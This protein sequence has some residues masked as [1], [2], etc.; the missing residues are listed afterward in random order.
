MACL[1]AWWEGEEEDVE[2]A[3]EEGRKG[4]RSMRTGCHDEEEEEVEEEDV[5]E[6]VVLVVDMDGVWVQR[7][8]GRSKP[9]LGWGAMTA[10]ACGRD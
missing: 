5:V 2:E 4:E 7:E 9:G 10:S 3:E 6:E 8:R 1:T